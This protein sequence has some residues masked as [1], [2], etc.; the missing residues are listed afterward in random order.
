[1]IMETLR[2]LEA[3][4]DAYS[5]ALNNIA[6]SNQK[7]KDLEEELDQCK[8]DKLCQERQ[9]KLIRSKFDEKWPT[10]KKEFKQLFEDP[11]LVL[12]RASLTGKDPSECISN[13]N[14]GVDK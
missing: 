11:N 8:R 3:L 4:V 2:E 1:M 13:S 5:A 7:C 9:L 6:Q 10:A 14:E 12:L